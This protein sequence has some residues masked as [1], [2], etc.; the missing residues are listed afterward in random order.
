MFSHISARSTQVQRISF[1]PDYSFAGHTRRSSAHL[2]LTH[3][4]LRT[5]NM[6]GLGTKNLNSL[7]SPAYLFLF[8]VIVNQCLAVRSSHGAQQDQDQVRTRLVH[9]PKRATPSRDQHT[10]LTL[11]RHVSFLIPCSERSRQRTARLAPTV[12]P[13]TRFET[14]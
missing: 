6:F 3:S 5:S 9:L 12:D 11:P 13:Q 2:N 14:R 1:P 10:N 8:I 7:V 4:N